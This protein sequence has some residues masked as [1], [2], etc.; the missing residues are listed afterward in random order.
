MPIMHNEAQH[1]P[2]S[3]IS[4]NHD[5]RYYLCRTPA[6]SVVLVPQFRLLRLQGSIRQHHRDLLII[7]T[8]DTGTLKAKVDAWAWAWAIGHTS[9][10]S[11]LLNMPSC[12]TTPC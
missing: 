9:D 1:S 12:N 6:K 7:A 3:P 11:V 2:C 8:L 10:I 4:A 5:I